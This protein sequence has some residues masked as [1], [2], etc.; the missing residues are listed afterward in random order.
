MYA[1]YYGLA[2]VL[3]LVIF[4]PWLNNYFCSD[5][6]P[7]ILRNTQLSWQEAP[8]WF[9]GLR[10]GSYRPVHDVFV[11]LC[12]RLF[13]VRP[14]GYRLASIVLYALISANVGVLA[15]LLTSDGRIG[16]LST[17]VFSVFATHAE[18]VLWF[19]AT[20]E[21]LA[22]LFV[23]FS[24]IS[25]VLFRRTGNKLWIV[26]AGLACLLGLTAKETAL[27]W[28]LTLVVYDV[29]CLEP[30]GDEKLSWRFFLPLLSIV[31]LWLAF[32][33]FRI[34][35]GSAYTSA[36]A[37]TIPRLAMN[38]VYYILIGVFALPNDYAFL[39]ARS[40]WQTLPALP[41]G[42]LIS[43]TSIIVIISWIW[44]RERIWLTGQQ[45][46]K[47]LLFSWVWIVVALGPV[48]FIV[49]ERSVFLS[50]IGIVL[51]FSILLIGA[52]DIARE[53]GKWMK[54]VVTAI[55]IL[56]VG[57]NILVL[58]YRS[59]WF[60]K[61]AEVSRTVLTQLDSRIESL[62][63]GTPVLLVNLPDHLGYTF[64]F[65]NT[66]PSATKVLEYDHDVQAVLDTALIALSPQQQEDYVNQLGREAGAIVFWYRDGKLVPESK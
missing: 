12:W 36:V 11:A 60:G 26:T 35:L 4:L 1:K 28:P 57:L 16:T 23:L 10:G 25:F 42:A 5:D 61:S 37:F 17:I 2:F 6:W 62:P 64:T 39:A 38:L 53:R 52:W 40:S 15:Y 13:G 54:Q 58:G 31:L 14:L 43:S 18:P 20:N 29:L 48:I 55:I 41:I 3:A 49:T 59:T 27:L 44:F 22:G 7:A 45:Y 19:A 21:L 56:H 65:R 30:T 51:T 9:A 32:L 47:S 34:P 46:K 66:F 24:T 63:A 33:L 8:S 50:S